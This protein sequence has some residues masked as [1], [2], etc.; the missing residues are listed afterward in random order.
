MNLRPSGYEP[1]ELPDCST[2]RRSCGRATVSAGRMTGNL[3]AS[4]RRAGDH[5]ERREAAE[6]DAVPAIPGEGIDG[7]SGSQVREPAKQLRHGDRPLEPSEPGAEAVVDAVTE[8]EVSR[9]PPVDVDG[10][11]LRGLTTL[12]VILG[13]EVAR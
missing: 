12:P 6:H 3:S 2:P 5:R 11:V 8:A 13:P 9:A 1:D 4:R 7:H 10:V